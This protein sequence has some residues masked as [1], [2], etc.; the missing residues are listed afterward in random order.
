M[1]NIFLGIVVLIAMGCHQTTNTPANMYFYL[2]QNNNSYSITPTEIKYNPMTAK[3]SSSGVYNGGEKT[4]VTIDKKMFNE[5]AQLAET[6]LQD[7]E[8]HADKRAMLTAVISTE[9]NEI[10]IKR[11]LKQSPT[12]SQLE[13]L[14]N[15]LLKKE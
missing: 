10:V 8:Y 14:L 6:L 7:S 13:T 1:K 3:N 11:F 12:R 15:N 4:T 9:R 2:D 5:I